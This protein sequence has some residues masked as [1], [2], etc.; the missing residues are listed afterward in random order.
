MVFFDEV[1]SF[2]DKHKSVSADWDL[3]DLPKRIRERDYSNHLANK[4]VNKPNA[5]RLYLELI[6]HDLFKPPFIDED[7]GEEEEENANMEDV[8]STNEEQLEL[9]DAHHIVFKVDASSPTEETPP[10]APLV[11]LDM[12][13]YRRR[14]AEQSDPSNSEQFNAL[15]RASMDEPVAVMNSGAIS[16]SVQQIRPHQQQPAVNKVSAPAPVPASTA[17][18][19]FT[20]ARPKATTLFANLYDS[21][22]MESN[23]FAEKAGPK[24]YAYQNQIIPI[25]ASPAQQEECADDINK[26][27]RFLKVNVAEALH[28]LSLSGNHKINQVGKGLFIMKLIENLQNRALTL[29]LATPTIDEESLLVE[30]A[31]Q[32]GLRCDRFSNI[33]HKWDSDYGVY[34]ETKAPD[35][36]ESSQYSFKPADFVICLGAAVDRRTAEK[37]RATPETPVAWMV[38][39]GSVEERLFEFIAQ[40][41]IKYPDCANIEGFEN[42]L[43]T[44]NSWPSY[45][46]YSFQELTT[47]VA[48]S[49]S[50]WLDLPGRSEYQFRS[51]E[52]LPL[53]YHFATFKVQADNDVEEMD[54]SSSDTEDLQGMHLQQ[55][56]IFPTYEIIRKQPTT[57]ATENNRALVDD[58]EREAKNLK[59]RY[60]AEYK[61]LLYKYKAKLSEYHKQM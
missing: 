42:L 16:A 10:T 57:T 58:Y 31:L 32:I 9:R 14:R 15:M 22:L 7:E 50:R 27:I 36:I 56:D 30:T 60:E 61:M 21:S 11:R 49:V 55:Q 2:L 51:I 19:T 54:I 38:T 37:L 33:L 53:S 8:V 13:E 17:P 59:A 6:P 18:S 48:N 5:D 39:L 45:G 46:Q 29:A 26:D 47:R 41:N 40:H 12:A 24:I 3:A 20:T 44:R 28:V 4:S 43:L 34:L 1:I 35:S 23:I 52:N 25:F